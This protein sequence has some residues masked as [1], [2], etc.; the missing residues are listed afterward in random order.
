MVVEFKNITDAKVSDTFR[1]ALTKYPIS[2]SY[3]IEFRQQKTKAS[4]MQARPVFNLKS[5]LFG[6]SHYRININKQVRNQK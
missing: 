3:L 6:F 5:F 4:T 2:H 1:E